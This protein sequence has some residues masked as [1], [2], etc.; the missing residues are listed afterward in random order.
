[1]RR[2]LHEQRLAQYSLSRNQPSPTCHQDEV[3][4]TT[5]NPG[6]TF[7]YNVAFPSNEPPGLYWYHPHVHGIAEHAVLGGASGAIVVDGIQDVQPAVSGLTQRILVVRDHNVPGNPAPTGN[8]PSWDVTLNFVPITSPTNPTGTNWV[9]AIFQMQ[10]GEREFLRVVNSSADTILDLQYV[11]DGTAQTMHVVAIDGVAVNS[12]SGPQPP[13]TSPVTHFVLPPAAR[14]E[15]I[16]SAPSRSVLVA[17]LVTQAINTGP[18]GD[19]DPL[20]PLATIQ[21]VNEA[22]ELGDDRMLPKF[23]SLNKKSQRFAAMDTAPIAAKR[24]VYFDENCAPLS[25]GCTPN[26]FFM[27]VVGK[28]EH[29]FDPNLPPDIVSTQGTVEQWV[30][31]NRAG[32]NHEFHFHQVHFMVKSQDNFEVNGS[33]QSPAVNGQFLDMI[34]VPYWDGNP[35]HPFPSVTVLIDFR[36]PDVGDFVFHCHILNHEDLGMMNIIQVVGPNAKNAPARD[37]KSAEA[38]ANSLEIADRVVVPSPAPMVH[39]HPHQ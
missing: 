29:I 31:Q 24:V 26:Q 25:T 30:I 7:Q 1:L 4:K 12:Q 3:I 19:D 17:Q 38:A 9:P 33:V 11:F 32:E 5:I 27:G 18:L 35:A 28:P 10:A 37:S 2:V 22:P 15:F 21:L 23:K 14:V 13:A 36:G 16:V 6:Q 20:R 39:P 8:V 34:Q